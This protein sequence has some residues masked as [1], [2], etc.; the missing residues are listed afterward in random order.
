[1]SR[2]LSLFDDNL[3]TAGLVAALFYATFLFFGGISPAAGAAPGAQAAF[4]P[5]IAVDVGHSPKKAG[6][7]S[8]RGRT[9]FRF[10]LD[11]AKDFV[12]AVEGRGMRAKLVAGG[13]FERTLP[14]RA[15]LA[16]GADLL[17]SIHHDAVQ[18]VYLEHWM[19]NGT[20]RAFSDRFSGHGLFVS[21]KNSRFGES[22]AAAAAIGEAL[23]AAGYVPSLHH[24]EDI[25]G[26]R[27]ELLDAQRGIYR[28]DDLVVLKSAPVPA[29]LVEA[30]I[31]LNR[32][33]EPRLEDPTAR[34]R[35]AETLASGVFA[36]FTAGGN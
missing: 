17:V 22:F 5:L 2:I 11:L 18:P 16:K 7:T 30:G 8:A 35:F 36:A 28:Y 29:L 3:K 21:K 13:D 25:P 31:I 9:E 34:R 12:A 20:R 15:K 23:R 24:A 6:A 32:T 1:M 33:D 4:I 26:E 10:N 19:V 27:R 14:E